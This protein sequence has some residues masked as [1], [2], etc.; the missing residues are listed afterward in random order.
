[1]TEKFAKKEVNVVLKRKV[2]DWGEVFH[3]VQ[4]WDPSGLTY[5]LVTLVQVTL[6]FAQ[7]TKFRD[8]A[9]ME[10]G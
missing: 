6:E 2:P 10:E 1:M 7:D 5:L 9:N 8:I 3:T 4:S